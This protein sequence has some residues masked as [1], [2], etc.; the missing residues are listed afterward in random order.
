MV[1]DPEVFLN[2][3]VRNLD[4]CYFFHGQGLIISTSLM[5]SHLELP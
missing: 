3:F 1:T 5:V 4:V 2:D